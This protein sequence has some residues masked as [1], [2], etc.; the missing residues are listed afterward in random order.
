MRWTSCSVMP[1]RSKPNLLVTQ[2]PKL[3]YVPEDLV[4]RIFSKSLPTASARLMCLEEERQVML[5]SRL[6]YDC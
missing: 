1:C 6:Q 3:A 4:S 2:Q 5:L